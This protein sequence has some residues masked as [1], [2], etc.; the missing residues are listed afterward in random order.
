MVLVSVRNRFAR[1]AST[2]SSLGA[3]AQRVALSSMSMLVAPRWMMPPP[4]GHCSAIGR[5][6]GHQVVADLGL[7]LSGAGDVHVVL[8]CAQVGHLLC[9]DQP[10]LA[11]CRRQRDPHAAPAAGACAPATIVACMRSLP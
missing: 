1:A 5:I 2:R 10:G 8:V 11:L 4:T 3:D 6:S 9:G 7:D